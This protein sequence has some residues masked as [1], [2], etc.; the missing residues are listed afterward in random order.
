MS[1]KKRILKVTLSMPAGDVVL[2]DTLSIHA[3]ISKAALAIQNRAVID[4]TGLSQTLREQLLSQFTAWNKRQVDTGQADQNW[5]NIT[6]EA[7]YY[8][9]AATVAAGGFATP[10]NRQTSIIYKGQI[11]L[12][13]LAAGPPNTTVR[14]TCYSRQIDKTTFISTP[15]PSQTT[16]YNYVKW[17]AQQMGFANNFI[18]D[19]SYNDVVIYNPARSLYVNAA[20]LIDIQNLYKPDIAAFIDDDL[21]IVKDRNKIINPSNISNVNEFIGTP[22]WN[23][24]GV[25]WTCMFDPTIKL[26][27]ATA[28]QSS[29]NP[30]TSGTYVVTALEYDLASRNGPWYVK[31]SGSPPA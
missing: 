20:L 22:C 28:I 14:L 21:L 9:P 2:D 19:T 10:E 13:D 4:I 15:A 6:V 30:G 7:G 18:C 24:W 12:C 31:S 1:L 23:E 11:V 16:F 26:A 25:D 27:Q 17:A 5:I 3:R 8:T 29:M